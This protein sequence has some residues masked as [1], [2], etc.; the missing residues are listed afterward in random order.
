MKKHIYKYAIE[1]SF[2]SIITNEN[3]IE[4]IERDGKPTIYLRENDTTEVWWTYDDVKLRDHDFN[5]INSFKYKLI[6]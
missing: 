2:F 1:T 5:V 3:D 6:G 4:K